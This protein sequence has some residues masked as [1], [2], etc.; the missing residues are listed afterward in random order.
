[1]YVIIP[2]QSMR[3]GE[4]H[5][6]GLINNMQS[7]IMAMVFSIKTFIAKRYGTSPANLHLLCIAIG[8]EGFPVFA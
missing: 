8:T 5:L 6:G 4:V 3:A 2:V 1:M 7:T